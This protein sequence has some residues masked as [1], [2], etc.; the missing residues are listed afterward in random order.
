MSLPIS[1]VFRPPIVER[2]GDWVHSVKA[3]ELC[4][5]NLPGLFAHLSANWIY[6][7]REDILEFNRIYIHQ[8]WIE[9]FISGEGLA[10][11]ALHPKYVLNDEGELENMENWNFIRENSSIVASP[12]QIALLEGLSSSE[13]LSDDEKLLMTMIL[14]RPL[15]NQLASQI[16]EYL[17]G[18]SF[19]MPNGDYH[20]SYDGL[21]SSRKRQAE[22]QKRKK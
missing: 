17:I 12:K 10:R 1:E 8:E 6:T 18:T 19:R 21:I 7:P 13:F 14:S 15:Q 4:G 9:L 11:F 3:A 2:K 5:L 22:F 16:I 20:R